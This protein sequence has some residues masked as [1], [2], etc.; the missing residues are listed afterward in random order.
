MYKFLRASMLA[1]ALLSS[2]NSFALDGAWR[3]KL[4]VNSVK[5]P[6][7]FNFATTQSG[8]TSCTLDSPMQGAKGLKAVVLYC[9]NDS[10]ALEIRSIRASYTGKIA[11][12]KIKGTLKQN[13][14]TLPLDLT[15]EKSIG[16]RRPQTPRAPFPYRS[17]DTTFTA[18]D[19]TLMAGT[20][21][22]PDKIAKGSPAVVMV[23]GSGPQNR[24]EELFEHKPFAVIADALARQGI[25]SFRYDDR[26]TAKSQ[27]DFKTADFDTF[28]S[29][30]KAAVRFVKSIKGIG[31][32]GILGHSEGGTI[33][34]LL[35]S[36]KVP[37]FAVSL[38]AATVDGKDIIMCQNELALGKLNLSNT[39]KSD[40]LKLLSITFDD[41]IAGSNPSEIPIDKYISDNSLDIPPYLLTSMRQSIAAGSNSHFRS[42]LSLKPAGSIR[43][44]KRPVF[45]LNGSLD[46]QVNSTDNLAVIK[47][48]MPKAVTKEYPGLNHLF[49]HATTGE[50]T[51]YADIT[52]TI[53][54]EVLADICSFIK[55]IVHN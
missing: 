37:D 18:E 3:G 41:I 9:D 52:E 50:I 26:G 10:V 24:D 5:L 27:G 38:A 4:D 31:R 49:Q 54:P 13:G 35:A 44:I 47:K 43:K 53:S 33:A 25:I 36:E 11:N 45:A 7:V 29:D 32:T 2:L 55:C 21:V 40:A 34:L 22:I 20:L 42:L 30:A 46:T 16:E 28:K 19:G 17:T 14:Y 39:Q 51:E 48:N 6:L 1:I 23:T 8:N 15:P 12:G